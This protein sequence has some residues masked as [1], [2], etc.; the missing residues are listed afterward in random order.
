[1][2]QPI[3]VPIRRS[4]HTILRGRFLMSEASGGVVIDPTFDGD[5]N[6]VFP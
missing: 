3:E 1:M 6:L 2:T 4:W 5:F